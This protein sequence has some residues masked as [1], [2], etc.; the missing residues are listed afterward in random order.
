MS[1]RLYAGSELATL[2]RQA[3]FGRVELFGSLERT[4]YDQTAT[5]LVAVATK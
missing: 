2:L 5:R 4:P 3:G 1:L